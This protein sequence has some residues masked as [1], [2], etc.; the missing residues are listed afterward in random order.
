MKKYHWP[1]AVILV[2][3][4]FC[5][6]CITDS[7]S[8][9]PAGK[10]QFDEELQVADAFFD[11]GDFQKAFEAYEKIFSQAAESDAK[12]MA[13][14]RMCDSQA[15]LFRYGKAAQL[16][17]DTP[18]PE[19]NTLKARTLFL[20]ANILKNFLLQ[21]SGV[22]GQDQIENGE[23]GGAVFKMTE[24]QIRAE[25][26]KSYSALWGLKDTLLSLPLKDQGYYFIVKE[27]DFNTF[28]SFFDFFILNWAKYLSENQTA[29]ENEVKLIVSDPFNPPADMASTQAPT[30][31]TS[32]ILRAAGLMETAARLNSGRNQQASEQWRIRRLTAIFT[33][34]WTR[35]A[36][37]KSIEMRQKAREILAAWLKTFTTLEAK[38]QAGFEAASMDNQTGEFVSAIQ[39]CQT[40]IRDYSTTFAAK[41]A[42][43][44]RIQ[45]TNP[46]LSVTVKN[47]T[48]EI[49]NTITVQ[50]RNLSDVY[51]RVF[52]LKDE[53]MRIIE[54]N[55]Q[56]LT[57][58]ASP[59]K[60][61][62]I[63]Q[64]LRHSA[65]DSQWTYK[66][67]DD[68]S[69][70]H[71]RTTIAPPKLGEGIYILESCN[72]SSFAEETTLL[73]ACTVNVSNTML[74]TSAGPGLKTMSAFFRML[75]ENGPREI[76]DTIFRSY[77]IDVKTGKTVPGVQMLFMLWDHYESRNVAKTTTDGS[78]IA[79]IESLVKL[80]D[81]YNYYSMFPLARRGDSWSYQ[82]QQ[83]NFYTRI[84]DPV[85]IFITTD[86]PIYRPGDRVSVKITVIRRVPDGYRTMPAGTPVTFTASDP[87][88]NSFFQKQ[89]MTNENGSLSLEFEIPRGRLLGQYSFNSSVAKGL[90][91]GTAS[92]YFSVE[93]YKRPEFEV[94][95]DPVDKEYNF[96]KPAVVS[97]SVKYYFGGPAANA[98]VHY[99]VTRSMYIPWQYRFWFYN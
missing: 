95:F 52:K 98:A 37:E 8:G 90:L 30:N 14:F 48:P 82:Q 57:S 45:I 81:D 26:D 62:T 94:T 43:S 73:Y 59:Y 23:P 40:I 97:G 24:V 71:I 46:F 78:G 66:T 29:G 92:G 41:K 39:L 3:A 10:T 86:R 70:K 60:E 96:G 13:F 5:T 67:G 93:E 72:E 74:F 61:N 7:V 50:T 42:E 33:V 12:T 84:P 15:H 85:E 27:I 16:V 21:Y 38:A 99:T 19:N 68:G 87:N 4:L 28:P 79:G 35:Q 51:L 56:M 20:I 54:Q 65:P 6:T 58:L 11:K 69:H 63:R 76:K 53:H 83:A 18:L 64:S 32:G 80:H 88:Y 49:Q 75:D 2:L 9:N 47:M 34:P 25:I 55:P 44:L 31:G 22:L 1:V 91:T 89:G 17:L 77:A 36:Q